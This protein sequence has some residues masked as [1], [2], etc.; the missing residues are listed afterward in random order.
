MWIVW[1]L[2]NSTLP[3]A[4]LTASI[5]WLSKK[6]TSMM[7]RGIA[8]RSSAVPRGFRFSGRQRTRFQTPLVPVFFLASLLI[9]FVLD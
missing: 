5:Y 3:L 2:Q 4:L 1:E 6:S 7:R 9:P 8:S